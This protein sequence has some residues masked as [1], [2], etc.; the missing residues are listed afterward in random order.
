ML[1]TCRRRLAKLI[2]AEN[3]NQVI[4]THNCSGALNQAI[5]GLLRPGDHVVT[6]VMEHN[7]VLRPL[8]ALAAEGKITLDIVSAEDSG[9]GLVRSQDIIAAIGP[10][11]KLVCLVHASN[12]TGSLQPVA[13]IAAETR[14]RNIPI[15]VDAAQSLGHVPIDVRAMQIDLLAMPGHKGLMGPLGTARC[16]CG[17]DLSTS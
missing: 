6:T 16:T 8:N 10:K 5:K 3:P 14:R 11:T 13:T 15:L 9:S 17:P 12:V 4:F 2:N 7:S 1:A